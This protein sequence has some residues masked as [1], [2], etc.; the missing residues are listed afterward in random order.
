M[1]CKEERRQAT[2]EFEAVLLGVFQIYFLTVC[3]IQ[4]TH[5]IRT[6]S[7]KSAYTWRDIICIIVQRYLLRLMVLIV[8]F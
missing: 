6:V 8:W 1:T 7:H 5:F 3:T 4:I 2:A